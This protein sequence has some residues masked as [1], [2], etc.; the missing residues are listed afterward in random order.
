[1]PNKGCRVRSSDLWTWSVYSILALPSQKNHHNQILVFFFL[2]LFASCCGTILYTRSRFSCCLGKA[3]MSLQHRCSPVGGA[4]VL[5]KAQALLRFHWDRAFTQ[6]LIFFFV[7]LM[8]ELWKWFGPVGLQ[9]LPVS[10]AAAFAVWHGT[11]V[12]RCIKEK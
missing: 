2:F 4:S 12:N 11:S 5:W 8:C 6:T 7:S 3:I 9:L 10:T 1:M